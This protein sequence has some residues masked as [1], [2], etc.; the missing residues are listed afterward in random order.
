MSYKYTISNFRTDFPDD[1][2]CLDKVFSLRYG[3]QTHC[4][5]CDNVFSYTRVKGRQCYQCD[6]CY[7]QIYPCAGTVFDSNIYH[8]DSI[9]YLL[10][11]YRKTRYHILC[12][13]FVIRSEEKTPY[14]DRC[15]R[16]G[17]QF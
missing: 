12:N 4:T 17:N 3:S 9:V 16:Q 6:K 14:Q 10:L 7:Y 8:T 1:N 11:L 13:G 15:C 2:T 5:K